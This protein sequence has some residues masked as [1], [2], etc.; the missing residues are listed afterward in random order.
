MKW[1]PEGGAPF[2][3]RN[4]TAVTLFLWGGVWP[5]VLGGVLG[6]FPL[7]LILPGHVTENFPAETVPGGVLVCSAV[8]SLVCW[9]AEMLGGVLAGVLV[10]SLV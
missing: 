10:C 6:A 5:G 4:R 8:C 2:P 1:N 9:C 3:W 7:K